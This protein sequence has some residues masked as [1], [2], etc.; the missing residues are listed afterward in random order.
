[1]YVG[2]FANRY[3]FLNDKRIVGALTS[4]LFLTS[5]SSRRNDNISLV[6]ISPVG[7][8]IKK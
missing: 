6:T 3:G 5:I 2:D 8:E 1:M 7:N 4:Q